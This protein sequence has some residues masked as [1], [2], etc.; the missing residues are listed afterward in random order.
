MKNLNVNYIPILKYTSVIESDNGDTRFCTTSDKFAKD[1]HLLL[2]NGFVSVSLRDVYLFS[3]GEIQLPDKVFCLIFKG[4]YENNYTQAFSI[5]KQLSIKASIFVATDLIGVFEYPGVENYSPHF[6]WKQAQEMIDSGLVSIYPLW[7]PFDNGRDLKTE[8]QNKITL[9][10][11]NLVG[12]DASFA[13]AYNEYDNNS[14]SILSEIGVTLNIID[15]FHISLSTLDQGVFPSIYV[16]H[17]SNVLEVIEQ[18][19]VLLED[20]IG[21]DQSN[22]EKTAVYCEPNPTLLQASVQLPI[23]LHPM[24]RNYLRH[25][26]PLSVVQADKKD[27]VER[28]I[29]SDYIE[30]IYKPWYNWFDYH[31]Y[32]YEYWD[33]IDYRRLSK[34][35]LDA[36]DINIIDFIING[37][38]IGYYSDIWLDTFYIPGKHGYGERHMTHGILIYGYNS[39]TS[40]FCAL[41]YTDKGQYQEMSIPIKA[42]ALACTNK[43]FMYINLIRSRKGSV[44]EYDVHKIRDGLYNYI[45]SICYDDNTRYSKKSLQ[46]YYGYEASVRF[47]ENTNNQAETDK[48]IHTT[49]MYG[50]TE[51]KRLM[52]WRLKYIANYENL[53]IPK[54]NEITELYIRKSKQ[55]MN[56]CLKFNITKSQN[57]SSS[58]VNSIGEMN[59]AEKTLIKSVIQALDDKYSSSKLSQ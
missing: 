13:V 14:L 1:M 57:I 26:F 50:Y 41:S 12:N 40:S 43:Y 10:N 11:D 45:N 6:D 42:V 47:L 4:G 2:E 53:L 48:Y 17:T 54:I 25:A 34:E 19:N 21:K 28:I 7:H 51:H 18:Y 29:L 20:A 35:I 9:L 15:S 56:L 36:N 31:N 55:L 23:E 49:A 22:L 32:L 52:M 44:V 33:C 59:S 37:L 46:Q 38:R 5:L 8:V 30:V 24:A 39:D 58:I 27:K 3:R 16:D